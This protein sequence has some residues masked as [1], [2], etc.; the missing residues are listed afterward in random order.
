MACLGPRNV[1]ELKILAKVFRSSNAETLFYRPVYRCITK[2]Q[3]LPQARKHDQTDGKHLGLAT[4]MAD[5]S[6]PPPQNLD[7]A[8][9]YP[10]PQGTVAGDLTTTEQNLDIEV[11]DDHDSAFGGSDQSSASTSLASSVFD[12]V[13]EVSSGY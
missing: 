3:I 12:Y 5:P 9:V 10:T 1:F 13:Y 6:S 11:E 7:H 4:Q 2:L 8:T